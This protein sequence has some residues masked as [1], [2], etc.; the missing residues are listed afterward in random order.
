MFLLLFTSLML[1]V[2]Q[3]ALADD[4]NNN[5]EN[6]GGVS[7]IPIEHDLQNPDISSWYDLDTSK[8]KGEI[9]TLK[10]RVSNSANDERTIVL[11]GTNVIT[12]QNGGLD[13][14]DEP[15]TTY[16]GVLDDRAVNKDNLIGLPKKVTLKPGEEREVEFDVRVPDEGGQFLAGLTYIHDDGEDDIETDVEDGGSIQI[17]QQLRFATTILMTNSYEERVEVDV[18]DVKMKIEH[19]TPRILV[20]LD[21][22]SSM[23]E[24]IIVGYEVVSRETGEVAF[25]G[26]SSG[27][28]MAPHTYIQYPIS[29]DGNLSAGEYDVNITLKQKMNYGDDEDEELTSRSIKKSVTV[30]EEQLDEIDEDDNIMIVERESDSND[31]KDE[32]DEGTPMWVWYI[33]GAIGLLV[34][35]LIIL[36]IVLV[37]RKKDDNKQEEVSEGD[38]TD[39]LG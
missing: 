27:F 28:L 6:E 13:F 17:K 20:D 7:M 31:S 14:V 2:P 32:K 24:S 39:E 9:I 4:N 11:E 19:G 3:L 29:W 25:E 38:N 22:H 23:M 34:I 16:T 18:K 12:V 36:I 10:A 21:N 1:L 5:E 30:E 37:K 26:E 15:K 33:V 8:H 35:T